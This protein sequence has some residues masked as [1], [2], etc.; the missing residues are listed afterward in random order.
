MP[1]APSAYALHQRQRWLRHGAHLWIRHAAARWVKP[2]TDPAE[3]YPTL[4]RDRAQKEAARER[5]RGGGRR[6][7]SRDRTRTPGAGGAA[8]GSRRTQGCTGAAAS[9]GS[10]IHPYPAAR[11]GRQS[12]RRAVDGPQRRPEH[13]GCSII[14]S[15][16]GTRGR[17]R[18]SMAFRQ[19][20]TYRTRTGTSDIA[21]VSEPS[22]N[23]KC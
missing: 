1:Q 12:A 4:A 15:P 6:L 7:R 17:M 23:S 2:G 21:W 22:G 20:N 9:G 10:K 8:R 14:G 18:N 16:G 11:A 13:Q 19:G 5:A 3:V